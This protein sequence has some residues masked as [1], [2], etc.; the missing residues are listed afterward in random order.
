M[1]LLCELLDREIITDGASS[2]PYEL[3]DKSKRLGPINDVPYEVVHGLKE[4]LG[5]S[6]V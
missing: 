3:M 5:C 2:V 4:G 1:I 6:N